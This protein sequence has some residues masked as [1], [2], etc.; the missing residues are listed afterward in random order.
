MG[1]GLF[2]ALESVNTQYEDCS[3][4][5]NCKTIANYNLFVRLSVFSTDHTATLMIW[6]S[7][8]NLFRHFL[9]PSWSLSANLLLMQIAIK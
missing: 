9:R 6:V 4:C 7:H 5:E 1:N 2:V 8:K 3:P